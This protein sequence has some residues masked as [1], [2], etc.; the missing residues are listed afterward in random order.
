MLVQ[1]YTRCVYHTFSDIGV[2]GSYVILCYCQ[3]GTALCTRVFAV[4]DNMLIANL[5]GDIVPH[6]ENTTNNVS[7]AELDSCYVV[8]I[9]ALLVRKLETP[10]KSI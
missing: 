9:I 7:V 3:L 6:H 4:Y 5:K 1:W 8:V 2:V 10:L